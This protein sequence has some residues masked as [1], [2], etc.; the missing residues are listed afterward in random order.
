MGA[1]SQAEVSVD[2]E[3]ALAAGDVRT[4]EAALVAQTIAPRDFLEATDRVLAEG[5]GNLGAVLLASFL[6]RYQVPGLPERLERILALEA[7]VGAEALADLA[8]VLLAQ[9]RVRAAATMAEAAVRRGPHNGR[10]AYLRARTHARCG[11]MDEAF[12]SI[13]RASPELLGTSGLVAQARYAL[14]TRRAAAATAAESKAKLLAED[15]VEASELA[16][17]AAMRQRIETLGAAAPRTFRDALAL[18]YGAFV[19]WPDARLDDALTSAEVTA[20]AD[21]AVQAM[22]VA[23][24]PAE[25][26]LYA[27]E[28]GEVLAEWLARRTER[29][30]LPW[31]HGMT[32][33]DG[34]WLCMGSAAAHPH[35]GR[36]DV[37]ALHDA[38]ETSPLRSLALVLPPGARAPWVPDLIGAIRRD[39]DLPW[40]AADDPEDVLEALS[41]ATPEAEIDPRQAME[42]L[43]GILRCT[44]LSPRP[45]HAPF[46]D[47][48]PS[49]DAEGTP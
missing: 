7:V 43:S 31:R 16:A 3:A 17:L 29:P 2:I 45:P 30:A 6:G 22:A 41:A 15:P 13:C 11:D 12:R 19:L 46:L 5:L 35:V 38:L 39:D 25:R 21:A 48:T 27:H 28:D 26:W 32:V 10:A 20:L 18:E 8:A 34:D 9:D 42:R 1:D 14:W 4:L 33:T 40:T 36:P 37:L 47:E 23:G 44:Q 24:L 49:L